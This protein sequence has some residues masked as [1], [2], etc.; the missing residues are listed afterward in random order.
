MTEQQ[1]AQ[2]EALYVEMYEQLFCYAKAT[3]WDDGRSKEAVQE[4]FRIACGKPE[5]L[6]SSENPRGWLVNTLK[7]VLRN[8][9]RREQRESKVFDP[10][11]DPMN[12]EGVKLDT[13]SPDLLYEDLAQ[14]GE[15]KL[16]QAL[17]EGHSMMELCQQLG[18][19]ES[20][21]KKRIQRSRKFL[22]KKLT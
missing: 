8:W 20:A 17:S 7:G 12:C 10:V 2:I 15:Y 13:L 16:L 22:R 14:T 5:A 3:L 19:S 4:T 21:C 6:E 9:I 18:I 1:I 11:Q